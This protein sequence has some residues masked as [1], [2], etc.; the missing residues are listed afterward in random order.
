MFIFM[1]DNVILIPLQSKID[2][3]VHMD[4]AKEKAKQSK[5]IW[6]LWAALTLRFGN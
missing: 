5:Q 2:C 4:S 3:I 1:A 6:K